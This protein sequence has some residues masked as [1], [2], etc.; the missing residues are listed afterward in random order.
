MMH[1]FLNIYRLY[2]FFF[3]GGMKNAF[4]TIPRRSSCLSFF[5][6][7]LLLSFHK[8]HIY[9]F[10]FFWSIC[11]LFWHLNV[12]YFFPSRLISLLKRLQWKRLWGFQE[13]SSYRWECVIKFLFPILMLRHRS[14]SSTIQCGKK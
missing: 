12:F 9:V 14:F 6:S 7:L 3:F 8:V 5:H 4:F 11:L 13:L 1:C 10:T 2:S